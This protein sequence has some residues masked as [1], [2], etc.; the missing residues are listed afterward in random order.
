MGYSGYKKTAGRVREH[1]IAGLSPDESGANMSIPP[2]APSWRTPLPH[3]VSTHPEASQ[4]LP[5]LVADV[6][7]GR[8]VVRCPDCGRPNDHG[9][10]VGFRA[11]H[12]W[13]EGMRTRRFFNGYVIAPPGAEHAPYPDHCARC[14]DKKGTIGYIYTPVD[15]H[16]AERNRGLVAGYIC[17]D[18]H[19]WET[20]WADVARGRFPDPEPINRGGRPLGGRCALYRHFDATGV[21]LYVGISERPGRRTGKHAESSDWVAFAARMEAEWLDSRELAVAREKEAIRSERPVFNRAHAVGNPDERI[22]HYLAQR[23][24]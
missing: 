1:P 18:S 11:S 15:L 24:S 13:C 23:G 22:A 17:D 8:W 2:R 6:E 12:C 20:W 7:H 5:V 9:P 10:E 21:L 4:W 19:G 3:E 16:P 14:R